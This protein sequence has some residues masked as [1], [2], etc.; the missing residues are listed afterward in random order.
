MVKCQP[1]L[2]FTTG[3]VNLYIV[4]KWISTTVEQGVGNKMQV[5]LSCAHGLRT[6][7]HE[8]EMYMQD[9]K[10]STDS[11]STLNETHAFLLQQFRNNK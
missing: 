8:L 7:K 9:S 3:S 11:D 6:K 10:G 2:D 5:H 1:N 4:V